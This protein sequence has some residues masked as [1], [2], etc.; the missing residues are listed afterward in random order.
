MAAALGS[1][2]LGAYGMANFQGGQERAQRHM[3][4]MTSLALTGDLRR[5]E[6]SRKLTFREQLQ[7][8][9]N[10]WLRGE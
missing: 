9:T 6:V 10:E 5:L 2:G 4:A 7:Q 3:A 8:E 1:L